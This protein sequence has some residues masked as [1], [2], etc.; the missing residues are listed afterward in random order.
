MTA[1]STYAAYRK[2]SSAEVS[3]TNTVRDMREPRPSLMRAVPLFL[4]LL[5][6]VVSTLGIRA[7]VANGVLIWGFILGFFLTLAGIV[8]VGPLLTY[9]LSRLVSRRAQSAATLIASRRI[10]ARR[11]GTSSS[12]PRARVRMRSSRRVRR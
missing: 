6:I 12:S 9:W 1:V 5:Q 3:A 10:S 8:V 11:R 2:I 4:G 7:D